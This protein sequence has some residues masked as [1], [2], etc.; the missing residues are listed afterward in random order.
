MLS[1]TKKYLFFTQMIDLYFVTQDLGIN[2]LEFTTIL[3]LLLLNGIHEFKVR[4]FIL[5]EGLVGVACL[6]K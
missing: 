6:L 2:R 5:E 1:I 3:W 4:F